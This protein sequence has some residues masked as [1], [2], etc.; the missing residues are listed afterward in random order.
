MPHREGDALGGAY[1]GENKMVR[2]RVL[3]SVKLDAA[4]SY[5]QGEEA[6]IDPVLARKHPVLFQPIEAEQALLARQAAKPKQD[7]AERYEAHMRQRLALRAQEEEVA[8]SQVAE[9]ERQAQTAAEL[10]E[11]ARVQLGAE[12]EAVRVSEQESV[13]PHKRKR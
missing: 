9:L 12:Q 7:A 8:R 13:P 5:R 2:V 1:K 4:T 6:E 11:A 3:A 10:A